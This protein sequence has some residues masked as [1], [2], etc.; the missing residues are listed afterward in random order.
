VNQSPRDRH[1]LLLA[2]RQRGGQC[3]APSIEPQLIEQRL[4]TVD[5]F[6]AFHSGCDERDRRVFGGRQRRQQIEL[7]EN[8]ADVFTAKQDPLVGRQTASAAPEQFHLAV[9]WIQQPGDHG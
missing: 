4:R 5:G 2:S 7:L 1:A 9:A 3:V 8:E 6:R